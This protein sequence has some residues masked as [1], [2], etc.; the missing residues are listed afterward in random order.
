MIKY[1]STKTH[2]SRNHLSHVLVGNSNQKFPEISWY[3][4][5]QLHSSALAWYSLIKIAH[6]TGKWFRIVRTNMS[7]SEVGSQGNVSFGYKKCSN[8]SF[9][10]DLDVMAVMQRHENGIQKTVL[11]WTNNVFIIVMFTIILPWRTFIS[12]ILCT[13]RSQLA[14]E[15]IYFYSRLIG[16]LPSWA[17][18]LAR[19]LRNRLDANQFSFKGSFLH[20][21]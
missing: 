3:L 16:N 14:I 19:R 8:M 20:L 6:G 5:I 4:A 1:V 13:F 7:I 12:S 2:H 21:I 18:L 17:G 9:V 15:P 11:S 10:G